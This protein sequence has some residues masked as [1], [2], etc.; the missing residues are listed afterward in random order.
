MRLRKNCKI[1]Q[2]FP[3]IR[4]ENSLAFS[5]QIKSFLKSKPGTAS[6]IGAELK[7]CAKTLGGN[8]RAIDRRTEV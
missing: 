3:F 1:S 4:H 5:F 2:Y 8:R 6:Q 7:S